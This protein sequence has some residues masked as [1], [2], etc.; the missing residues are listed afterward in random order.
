MEGPLPPRRVGGVDGVLHPLE[1][2]VIA[3][4]ARGAGRGRVRSPGDCSLLLHRRHDLAHD[5]FNIPGLYLHLQPPLCLQLS[6]NPPYDFRNQGFLVLG[7]GT[8][9]PAAAFAKPAPA[10]KPPPDIF[11]ES[12]GRT[13]GVTPLSVACGPVCVSPA[14]AQLPQGLAV[15]SAPVTAG[16]PPTAA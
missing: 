11:P 5:A 2:S 13:S 12:P 1:N 3:P 6:H 9:G 7:A 8:G 4:G 10:P 15:R 16:F 14:A